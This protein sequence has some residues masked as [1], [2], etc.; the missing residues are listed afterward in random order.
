MTK[1]CERCK[2]LHAD[3]PSTYCTE[4]QDLEDDETYGDEN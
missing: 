4:C 3:Y 1:Y 2:N